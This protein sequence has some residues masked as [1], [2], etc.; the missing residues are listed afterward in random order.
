MV[1]ITV[2]WFKFYPKV[3]IMDFCPESINKCTLFVSIECTPECTS[4]CYNPKS[5]L[6]R[7]F[8][9][10]LRPYLSLRFGMS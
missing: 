7:I 5:C 6:R 9:I 3:Q 10:K 4:K 2:F 8:S 1:Q